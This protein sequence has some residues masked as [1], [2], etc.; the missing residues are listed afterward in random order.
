MAIDSITGRKP[1]LPAIKTNPKSDLD[2]SK[3]VTNNGNTQD[4][5]VAITSAAQEIKKVFESSPDAAVDV[6]RVASIKKAV[7]DGSYVVN[8]EKVAQKMIQFEKSLL[9]DNSS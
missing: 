4:D 3:K 2:N 1:D 7:A 9:K 8:A 5:T 6:D